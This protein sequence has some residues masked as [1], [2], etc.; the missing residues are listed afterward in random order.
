M[1]AL[2]ADCFPAAAALKAALWGRTGAPSF[3]GWKQPQRCGL[4]LFSMF[5]CI[6]QL[7][8]KMEQNNRQRLC[9]SRRLGVH[10]DTEDTGQGPSYVDKALWGF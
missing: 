2:F 4:Q 5:C 8:R 6:I 1:L 7:T 3:A 10:R 9:S